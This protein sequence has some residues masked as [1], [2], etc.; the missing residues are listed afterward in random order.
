MGD[1]VRKWA[2][3][4]NTQIVP[5]CEATEEDDP[6]FVIIG[7]LD[8]TITARWCYNTQ[9]GRLKRI[10]ALLMLREVVRIIAGEAVGSRNPSLGRDFRALQF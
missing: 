5:A 6:K 4:Q 10:P 8:C 3:R 2:W 1:N 7:R 9:P